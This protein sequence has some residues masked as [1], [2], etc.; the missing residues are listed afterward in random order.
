M[1]YKIRP[2]RS[3][4]ASKVPLATDLDIGELAINMADQKIYTKTPANAIVELGGGTGA[5]IGDFDFDHSKLQADNPVFKANDQYLT[6]DSNGP[7]LV[8]TNNMSS[9]WTFDETGNLTLPTG[10]D[11]LDSDG[12]SVLGGS[13][14]DLSAV[15]QD[16]IPDGDLTRSL[17]SPSHQW[18]DLYVGNATIYLNNVP[19]GLDASQNLTFNGNV[20]ANSNGSVQSSHLISP[21]GDFEV[22]LDDTGAVVLS[23][24]GVVKNPDHVNMVSDGWVQMQWVDTNTLENADPNSTSGPTNWIYVDQYGIHVE[25]NINSNIDDS[26]Q[27]YDWLFDIYGKLTM[28]VGGDIVDSSGNSVLGGGSGATTWSSIT[29]KPTFATV[30][31]SG[32]Y[33]D[34]TNK[35]SL[36]SGNYNDLTN[37]PTIPSLTGYATQTYVDT[38]VSNLVNSAPSALNTLSELATALGS[39]ANFSTTVSTALGN[40]LRVDVN[41]QALTSTQ[42]Q[43]AITN[44]GLATVA[45]SGSYNDLSNKPSLFSGN[46]NDLTNQPTIPTNL[47]SLTDVTI[48]SATNGQVLKFNGTA[49]VNGTD[50]T[51]GGNP[52]N[53]DLNTNDGVEFSQVYTE[54]IYLGWNNVT[55][56]SNQYVDSGQTIDIW[57]ADNAEITSAKFTVQFETKTADPYYSNFDTMTCEI[58]LAKKRVNNAWTDAPIVVYAMVHTSEAPLAYFDSRIDND[59]RAILTCTPAS[60]ITARSYLKIQSMEMQS[61]SIQNDWC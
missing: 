50:S 15:D 53:Q 55:K 60:G 5:D 59:G 29:G 61:P 12:N 21:N 18:A 24:Y 6:I 9:L 26:T 34:L 44:L 13:T 51:G 27:R 58:V 57:T 31:T 54:K 36:F 28:P 19:L 38:A 35:P 20:V 17:G 41:S 43:N 23:S 1:T 46:Y 42:K 16:I 49:W 25:T 56:I 30:A 40:R 8:Y 32:S 11:I 7:V 37:K 39:D 10:G 52:F 3:N 47:D 48:T 33:A 22:T 14:I 2:K 45:S 4:V